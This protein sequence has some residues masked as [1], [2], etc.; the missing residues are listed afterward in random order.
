MSA[1]AWPPEVLREYQREDDLCIAKL[2][3]RPLLTPQHA[4]S[5]RYQQAPDSQQVDGH[6][7][8]FVKTEE[9]TP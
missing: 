1:E 2:G 8:C 4:T 9:M 7:R 3:I 5:S 6:I